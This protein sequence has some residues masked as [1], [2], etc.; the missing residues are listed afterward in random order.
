MTET[1]NNRL[2]KGLFIVFEGIDGVGKTTQIR[3]L[4]KKYMDQG[5]SIIQTKEPT[6]GQWGQKIREIE[7]H[8][9]DQ[10]SLD[11]EL[12]LFMKDREEHVSSVIGPAL[13]KKQIILS[14]RYY[15]SSIAYQGALGL[16]PAYI[17][18]INEERFPKPDIVIL[19]DASPTVSISRII[20]GRR[21]KNNQGYEQEDYLIEVRKIFK[22]LMA[23]P[24]VQEIDGGLSKETIFKKIEG[25]IDNLVKPRLLP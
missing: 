9:R 4:A 23:D 5:F 25:H 1:L 3:L 2:N 10:I 21:E 17:Q 15:Y 6:N 20:K 22:K 24:I 16:D 11:Y 13:K 7:K 12:N 18:K 14:D 8:G 19:L